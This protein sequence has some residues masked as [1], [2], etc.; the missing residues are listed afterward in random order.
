M[1]ALE[2]DDS[3][4]AERPHVHSSQEVLTDPK[5]SP[6]LLPYGLFTV[7][8][9]STLVSRRAS[10]WAC[11]NTSRSMDLQLCNSIHPPSTPSDSDHVALQQRPAICY[12]MADTHGLGR[13]STT[14]SA[15]PQVCTPRS[16]SP[17]HIGQDFAM[18]AALTRG[19][20]F[21]CTVL[22]ES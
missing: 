21:E 10:N 6:K 16:C 20:D 18:Q 15:N 2:C 22:F 17:C 5:R 12:M 4:V 3:V 13:I 7:G 9:E 8:W 11:S 1:G 14:Y 19:S